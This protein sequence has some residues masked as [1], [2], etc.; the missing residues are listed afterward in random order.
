MRY[1]VLG[2]IRV[3]DDRGERVELGGPKPR[4]LVAALALHTP[5]G[6]SVD[7]LVD[8]LWGGR[9]P[10]SARRT[11]Q[12]NV[13][14]L[15]RHVPIE[16][17][18]GGY[19]L[20][21]SRPE[22][23]AW[24]FEDTR[25]APIRDRAHVEWRGA[26]FADLADW[27]PA[28]ST[29]V[30]LHELW[31]A[32]QESDLESAL[33]GGDPLTVVA[34]AET[35]LAEHPTRERVWEILMRALHA[36]GRPTEALQAYRRARTTLVEEHGVEPGI[37]LGEIEARILRG[38]ST[39][40][41]EPVGGSD[42]RP[43]LPGGPPRLFGRDDEL[44][45]LRRL[46]EE[47]SLVTLTGPGGIGK[48]SLALAA[49]RLAA[50]RFP[51]PPAFC[52]L[53]NVEADDI[54][55]EM[56]AAL[57]LESPPS[58]D[59]IGVVAS[60]LRRR[61]SVLVID[62]AEHVVDRVV[63]WVDRIRSG[64]PGMVLLVTSRERL[65]IPGERTVEIGPLASDGDA[66]A[67]FSTVLG[68]AITDGDE[69]ESARVLCRHVD[70]IPLAIEL[71][72]ARAR[73]LGV[74]AVA[75][76]IDR[77]VSITDGPAARRSRHGTMS[78]VI[79]WSFDLLDDD[80]R[81]LHRRLAC[82]TGS[83]DLDAIEWVCSLDDLDPSGIWDLVDSLVNRSMLA[84]REGPTGTRFTQLQPIREHAVARLRAADE[85]DRLSAAHADYFAGRG[86]EAD[87]G[88]RSR[89]SSRWSDWLDES[90]DDLRAANRWAVA[91]GDR[92]RALATSVPY[93]FHA[94][95]QHRFEIA[96]WIEHALELPD[97]GNGGD[98]AGAVATVLSTRVLLG[99]GSDAEVWRERL[100]SLRGDP[101]AD[102]HLAFGRA[103]MLGYGRAR[104]REA[105]ELLA[106]LRTDDPLLRAEIE[107]FRVGMSRF[108]D[109][110]ASIA[111][112]RR[113]LG[114]ARSTGIDA[115][116]TAMSTV[117][118]EN[119]VLCG[120]LDEGRALA[121]DAV[122]LATATGLRWFE[123]Q[124][125]LHGAR[126]DILDDRRALVVAG[127][128]QRCLDDAVR[129]GSTTNVW[130]VLQTT[131][132]ALAR[133]GLITE[134]ALVDRACRASDLLVVR[135]GLLLRTA[136]LDEVAATERADAEWIAQHVDLTDVV[137]VATAALDALAEREPI[138]LR[139]DPTS[140]QRD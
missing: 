99:P 121:A 11:V 34:R 134:A 51:D 58:A 103:R 126:A 8:A 38:D 36:A 60:A 19:R 39:S 109:G 73:A 113:A 7:R 55:F 136:W 24:A 29:A 44:S 45:E 127:I 106:T 65:S 64:A 140:F 52:G 115:C 131:A 91:S 3:I 53:A 133:G 112:G 33:V 110:A 69:L 54:A 128:L 18:D 10:S 75:T 56:A 30:R 42:R 70:G 125:R 78:A 86:P 137:G 85:S 43:G 94:V 17:V 15:R 50:G 119:L 101:L 124:A 118:A 2:P 92:P 120:E 74:G 12:A 102:V 95:W 13:S 139:D 71:V 97:D 23:D 41:A 107:L 59:P 31:L 25:T 16:R 116:R 1:E 47:S 130:Y 35:L 48:T 82:F 22:V 104:W 61:R 57:G 111:T 21:A 68:R 117:L 76:R 66:I 32:Q 108:V 89:D 114:W 37:R 87:R 105:V 6:V 123:N 72:A 62:N 90:V 93:R 28:R 9:P 14:R 83:F 100:R 40:I 26:A 81:I 46:L 96:E 49:T 84:A 20:D 4:A 80:E 77:A 138:A 98:H 88:L 63:E 27:L 122:E 135:N 79:D 67:V 5:N 129:V 132:H